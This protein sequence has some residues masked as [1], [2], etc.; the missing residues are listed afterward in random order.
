M[1]SFLAFN[2]YDVLRVEEK[3]AIQETRILFCK[4]FVTARDPDLRR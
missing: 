1:I 2:D 3:S 4:R